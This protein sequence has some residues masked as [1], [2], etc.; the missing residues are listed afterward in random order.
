MRAEALAVVGTDRQSVPGTDVLELTAVVRNRA[1]FRMA[2]P[3]IELTL[4]D[5]QGRAV[6]RK[7]FAPADYLASSGAARIEEGLDAG[8]DLSI[9]VTFEARGLTAVGFVVYPFF[10]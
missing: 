7:V 4:T 9:R 5:V 10:L 6:A 1:T 3:S 2:L 8:A